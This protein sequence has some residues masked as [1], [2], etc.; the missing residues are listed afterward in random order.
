MQGVKDG[1]LTLPSGK[2]FFLRDYI[3]PS[4]LA[5]GT[6]GV[7]LAVLAVGDSV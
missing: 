7:L 6:C 2:L 3:S 4:Q 1:L 5:F